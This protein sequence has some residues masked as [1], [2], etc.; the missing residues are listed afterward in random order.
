MMDVVMSLKENPD[1][2]YI[3][4]CTD[5]ISSYNYN[6]D[7]LNGWFREKPVLST[8]LFKNSAKGTLAGEGAFAV[9]VNNQAQD[10][11]AELIGVKTIHST[12]TGEVLDALRSFLSIH[13]PEGVQPDLLITGEN[14]DQR[15]LSYFEAIESCFRDTISVARFKHLSGEYCTASSFACWLATQILQSGEIPSIAIKKNVPGKPIKRIL[16]CNNYRNL[17][18]SFILLSAVNN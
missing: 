8:E 6:I 17:Q 2:G 15:M 9:W 18:H 3:L 1:A 4:G 12:N 14:G 13:L 5:E 10:A 7:R 11:A 16:I